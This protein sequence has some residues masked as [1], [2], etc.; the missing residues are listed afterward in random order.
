MLGLNILLVALVF[1]L[2]T[3]MPGWVAALVVGAVLLLIGGIDGFSPI[4]KKPE[5]VAAKPIALTEILTAAANAA[6]AIGIKKVLE[7]G[8]ERV[9]RSVS[10]RPSLVEA[11]DPKSD[12]T[13][14][15]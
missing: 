6:V 10:R 11:H 9:N 8:L 14:V 7:R 15:P 12:V 3:Y 13:W 4:V 1:F 2:A 5:R